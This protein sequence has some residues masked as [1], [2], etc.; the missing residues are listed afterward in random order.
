MRSTKAKFI[1]KVEPDYQAQ[2]LVLVSLKDNRTGEMMDKAYIK[3]RGVESF[4]NLGDAIETLN[5]NLN[6]YTNRCRYTETK[7]GFT[8]YIYD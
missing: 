8:I 5:W 4:L 1:A 6:G 7:K 3:E 2:R